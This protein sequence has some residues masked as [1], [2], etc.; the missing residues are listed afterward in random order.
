MAIGAA[1]AGVVGAAGSALLKKAGAKKAANAQ[2]AGA[3]LIG[4][5][6]T[7]TEEEL[8]PW[9]TIG[10]D[11]LDRVAISLGLPDQYGRTEDGRDFSEFFKSPG[12]Q[13][14]FDE[15]QKAV[16]RSA[17]ARGSLQSGATMK[18]LQRQGQGEASAEY[19]NY[20]SQLMGLSGQ[21]LTAATNLGSLRSNAA[22]NQA[23][24]LAGAGAARASGYN[25][26]GEGLTGI[27]DAVG[28]YAGFKAGG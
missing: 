4:S 1:I 26:L 5:E 10:A 22:A 28:G 14:R 11:A 17:A 25:A 19:G 24:L 12:Y 16:E 18:A 8:A 3:A 27:T 21:G 13:F 2:E 23:N 7:T 15:G 6:Q 20:V 9:R